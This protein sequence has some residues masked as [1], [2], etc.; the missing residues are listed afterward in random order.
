[1]DIKDDLRN[2]L[3]GVQAGSVDVETGLSR[4]RDLTTLELGHT[5]IDL[6]RPLR[7]GFPVERV[8]QKQLER[9]EAQEEKETM[10]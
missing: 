2:L 5:T 8:A 1:M 10:Q 7:N 4:L 6:H 9:Y 3:A